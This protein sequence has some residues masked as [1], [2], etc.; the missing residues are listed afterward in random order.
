MPQ[1]R[2]YDLL[3]RYL[4][5]SQNRRS[6]AIGE[7]LL[8]DP[9]EFD[10]IEGQIGD[11]TGVSDAEL[12]RDPL[13][14][15]INESRQ[16]NQLSV[17]V[18]ADIDGS[19][20]ASAFYYDLLGQIDSNGGI[21]SSIRRVLDT[22]WFAWTP[23]FDPDRWMNYQRYVWLGEGEARVNGEY[24]TKDPNG[25]R[26]VLHLV[27]GQRQITRQ[28]VELSATAHPFSSG[29][30]AGQLREDCT[31]PTR[32]IYRWDGSAWNPVV[33]V[34]MAD[35][36]E[37]TDLPVGTYIY[38]ARAGY[39]HN[40]PLVHVYHSP[41]ARWISRMAV[42]SK[43]RPQSPVDGMIWEDP[44]DGR[45]RS[46]RRYSGTTFN[47]SAI[48]FAS[49]TT[50][51][52][53]GEG[54]DGDVVYC[55]L[56][57]ASV[58]DG[59]EKNNWWYHYDDLSDSDKSYLARRA[60]ATRPILQLWGCME[61]YAGSAR[62]ARHDRP[63]YKIY[64]Y[65]A[66]SGEIDEITADE[67]AD[68]GGCTV[69]EYK[70]GDGA[71]DAIL[72][73]PAS[74][75]DTGEFIFDLTLESMP[76][77]GL[78]GYRYFK[79][80][81]IG[82]MR[83]V[84]QEVYA[85]LMATE[86]EFPKALANNPDH[87]TLTEFSRSEILHSLIGNITA[88]GSTSIG[89]G[90][91][92]W[93]DM[94]MLEGGTLI[95]A[96]SSMLKPMAL[97]LDERLD[98]PAAIRAMSH[99]T[100]RFYRRFH[101]K[102]DELWGT[103]AY[104][105][106]DD[107]LKSGVTAAIM[108]DQVLTEILAGKTENGAF[109]LS[110]MGTYTDRVTGEVKPIAIPSSPPRVSATRPYVPMSFS[111]RGTTRLRG[112]DGKMIDSYGDDRDL[113]WLELE[114]R[115][116][117]EVPAPRKVETSTVSATIQTDPWI[118]DRYISNE[119]DIPEL[120]S[121][122]IIVP[123][124]TAVV[125]PSTATYFSRRHG[126]LVAY[127]GSAWG[128]P[129]VLE[130]GDRFFG[131]SNDLYYYNGFNLARQRVYDWNVAEGSTPYSA[132]E[133]RRIAQREF[134]RWAI[135]R[136]K[137]ATANTT[138]YDANDP[139]TWNF[140]SA[141]I[142]GH[143]RGIYRR[144]YG[145]DRPHSH[146]WEIYGF[147]VEPS[148]WRTTFVPTTTAA[149]GT[150]RYGSAHAMW[151]AIKS[152]GAGF[153]IVPKDWQIPST[154]IPVPVDTDGELLDPVAAG[155]VDSDATIESARSDR[156]K[157]GDFG[158]VEAE[159]W[160]S[161]EAA[162][163]MSLVGFLMK[164]C[165]FVESTWTDY[166][167]P[168]GVSGAA[169]HPRPI[170]VDATTLKRPRIGTIPVHAEVLDDG[171]TYQNPALVSWISESLI[172]TG[173]DPKTKF[174]DL[175]RNAKPSLGW[176]C[177]G[178]I[179]P[180]RTSIRT[181]TG[182]EIPQED[183]QVLV[184]ESRP[185]DLRFHSG[186][187]IV[188]D[189]G[190]AFRVYGY[191][192]ADPY[193]RTIK[194]AKP[195]V[196]GQVFL[197]DNFTATSG[198]TDFTVTS[199]R[200]K[201]SEVGQLSVLVDGYRID[202][203]YVTITEP[204][205]LTIGGGLTIRAGQTVSVILSS[206]QITQSTRQRQFTAGGKTFFYYPVS[207]GE[208]QEHQYGTAF[209]TNQD[210]VEFLA[211][212]GKWMASQG[213]IYGDDEDAAIAKNDWIAVA[214]RFAEWSI[215][216]AAGEIFIDVAGGTKLR[217]RVD[218]GHVMDVESASNGG[219]SVLDMGSFP[220]QPSE[221]IVSR[222]GGE[223]TIECATKEIYGLRIRINEIEHAVMISSTT[224]FN[225][226]IYQPVTGLRHLR[227]LV[228]TYRSRGWKGRMEAPGHL[229][230]R[231]R[232][233]PNFEK[234][235]SDIT[236]LYD[237]LNPV[238]DGVMLGQAWN[239]Y[240]WH[241]KAYMDD[242]G[243]SLPFA[244]QYHRGL[245]RNKGTGTAFK[246][247][248]KGTISGLDGTQLSENWAWK[249]AEYGS[250]GKR[251]RGRFRIYER[252]VRDKVQAFL[253]TD[254]ETPQ[255]SI[256]EVLPFDREEQSSSRWVIPPTTSAGVTNMSFV[257]DASG[258]PK[259]S[260]YFYRMSLVS[261]DSTKPTVQRFFHWD[262]AAGLHS[263][264][265]QSEIDIIS[266]VDPARYNQG[267][268]A[269]RAPGFEWGPE[270][271]GTVWWDTSKRVY[272]DYRATAGLRERSAGWGKIAHLAITAQVVN[273]TDVTFTTAAAHGYAAGMGVMLVAADG[274]RYEASIISIDDAD[275]FTASIRFGDDLEP[276]FLDTVDIPVFY[277]V[278]QYDVTVY[279]WVAS[280][281]PPVSYAVEGERVKDAAAPSYTEHNVDGTA[282][283]CFWVRWKRTAAT[284]KSMSIKRIEDDLRDPTAAGL[285]WFA[286]ISAT[287]M[288]ANMAGIQVDDETAVDV[289]VDAKTV[290]V[291]SEWA[292][293][294]DGHSIDRTPTEV[295]EKL[296]DSLLGVD[297][298]GG[299]VPSAMLIGEERYGSLRGQ[300]V[301]RDTA[302]ARAVF[303]GA[304][305]RALRHAKRSEDSGFYDTFLIAQHGTWWQ[306]AQYIDEDM[307]DVQVS[308]IATDIA[309][310]NTI[311]LMQE[312][313]LIR[314]IEAIQDPV[315]G[316]GNYTYGL[317]KY[318]D[319]AWVEFSSG[320]T[321]A[322]VLP[323]LWAR[324]DTR[325]LIRDVLA[326]IEPIEQSSV[327][328]AMISE[329]LHQND[330]C[331][332]CFKT[333][334]IDIVH[335]VEVAQPAYRPKDELGMI[336]DNVMETKP[337]HSKVRDTS[338]IVRPEVDEARTDVDDSWVIAETVRI[339]RLSTNGL[340]DMGWD[341]DGW[342]SVPWDLQPWEMS[343]QGLSEWRTLA[344][345]QAQASVREYTVDA[346]AVPG[347]ALRLL[348]YSGATETVVPAHELYNELDTQ[349]TVEFP[350]APP[351]GLTYVIQQ[352]WAIEHGPEPALPA[353][354]S[355]EYDWML[356]GERTFEH[357]AIR[358]EMRRLSDATV[359]GDYDTFGDPDGYDG[360]A[361]GE[362][363]RADATDLVS[364]KVTTYHSEA[365]AGWDA[366]PWDLGQW[367]SAPLYAESTGYAELRDQSDTVSGY[368]DICTAG[369]VLDLQTNDGGKSYL[370][371]VPSC[372]TIRALSTAVGDLVEGT[373][374]E[375]IG[376]NGAR[377][378]SRANVA[379]FADGDTRTFSVTSPFGI[380]GIKIGGTALTEGA[381]YQL[382][383]PTEVELID[384]SIAGLIE[385]QFSAPANVTASYSKYHL[386]SKDVIVTRRLQNRM[387]DSSL[388]PGSWTATGATIG[389]AL[390]PPAVYYARTSGPLSGI[391]GATIT[392]SSSGASGNIQQDLVLTPTDGCR[393]RALF[394]IKKV[395]SA[396]AYPAFMVTYKGATPADSL[397]VVDAVTGEIK[398]CS[399]SD[400]EAYDLGD[401]WL[402]A[403]V[404]EN[405]DSGN[406]GAEVRFYPAYNATGTG[407]SAPTATGSATVW[408]F[409]VADAALGRA[410]FYPSDGA[411]VDETSTA[412][413][414]Y[415]PTEMVIGIPEVDAEFTVFYPGY[416][417]VDRLRSS[418]LLEMRS[419]QFV[420]VDDVAELR[421]AYY[422]GSSFDQYLDQD[423]FLLLETDTSTIFERISGG[424]T[425]YG[426]AVARKYYSRRTREIWTTDG[427]PSWGTGT[428]A[429]PEFLYAFRGCAFGTHAYGRADGSLD[430]FPSAVSMDAYYGVPAA[431]HLLWVSARGARREDP[432]TGKIF[433]WT[434]RASATPLSQ[435]SDSKR[436]VL[437]IVGTDWRTAG[438]SFT[439]AAR[440]MGSADASL[441]NVW[442]AGASAFFVVTPTTF[443]STRVIAE[444][445]D[446]AGSGG[447]SISLTSTGQVRFIKDFSSSAA[448]WTTVQTM[449][450]GAKHYIDV[451]YTGASTADDPIIYIDGAL[452]T[453]TEDVAPSGTPSDDSSYDLTV[454]AK[455]DDSSPFDGMVHELILFGR[456]LTTAEAARMR[457]NLRDAWI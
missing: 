351:T 316:P 36:P 369:S 145:T 358:G 56:D 214:T 419:G 440:R 347:N 54:T 232:L 53:R 379:F 437:S 235:A 102:L 378:F 98:L 32:P 11:M 312:G 80:R 65:D 237:P 24:V 37:S 13:V 416:V 154:S 281:V 392:D 61:P 127:S 153:P 389:A 430:D 382:N 136:G 283:Y 276:I 125:G 385:V 174:G 99:E 8:Y 295:V 173:A 266:P 376:R 245:I 408:G 14:P 75:N 172:A 39:M 260:E 439:G 27:E 252:D 122:V 133:F 203:R 438:V 175:V 271:A 58:A 206:T 85:P 162:F 130:A 91:Y 435:A 79:D 309:D 384:G 7:D 279:Q 275:S 287:A 329:M 218:H 246:A 28:I 360:G 83:G 82:K 185:R 256:I 240:G 209:A 421:S 160:E 253:F 443:G 124:Y 310:R 20:E 159:F 139:F 305:N 217:F 407:T 119:E 434:N 344:T 411:D 166:Y 10:P 414:E 40:R 420:D 138:A 151:T 225:D 403:M 393:N 88:S 23:P 135:A 259:P 149:D 194:G 371:F 200:L 1:H 213:W 328:S 126:A 74:L 224:K 447:W 350:I 207:T 449:T 422:S 201:K 216:R 412:V 90:P 324:N 180:E 152:S 364:I 208:I 337:F 290:D 377:V 68:A 186:V 354:V 183:L 296:I 230:F 372:Y 3:P 67:V 352:A 220:I 29:T 417:P 17:A 116:Y 95:D 429:I 70:R 45:T 313:D 341:A 239:L 210:V 184:H 106:P 115:F 285:P 292:L 118:I 345:F 424:W 401:Y 59:W 398:H 204:S 454:G 234:Q 47:W 25:S 359:V 244:L 294:R 348:A 326:A 168:V 101:R 16:R 321:T 112:H 415:D 49:A 318:T 150:P 84:W 383:S 76:I 46:L 251:M 268:A 362:R 363:A 148:W 330:G 343:E 314:V 2:F 81:H 307:E 211:D 334:L 247:Y 355:A 140:S 114:N 257:V 457:G 21:T 373:D 100:G 176:R 331:S 282:L 171:S 48:T 169:L 63:R 55:S 273:D 327:V 87:D 390:D 110:D 381:D 103:G 267:T 338:T 353:A 445:R 397:M 431:D 161:P 320:A 446:P 409:S 52:A 304:L 272:S 227:L 356:P 258:A 291:H 293:I 62:A 441:D 144:I 451:V 238:D 15:E 164:P 288:A 92:R 299:A 64:A 137:D 179:N 374:F 188:K 405:N 89:S 31:D 134:E 300:T 198:Q 93:G 315:L 202:R 72:A 386:L 367:D 255:D 274:K 120:P 413:L 249:V 96:Q 222:I 109:W 236:R 71:D 308:V 442:A 280:A 322:E 269:N 107:T 26:T 284:G 167:L 380:S 131:T 387:A 146:P 18:V 9:E 375:R 35:V 448:Q 190:G 370:A 187:I 264:H 182:I 241:R 298:L 108:V 41:G 342:D 156:W 340:D 277:E 143:W 155:I 346:H 297:E 170:I 66:G 242:L 250:L 395:D 265:A 34:P 248:S 117:A 261:V 73:F 215:G 306:K 399:G 317:Y 113:V 323:A 262:P 243:A 233:L 226:L 111:F 163:I 400:A 191:D 455:T 104:S 128:D 197:R 132:N 278:S 189:A 5:T 263:P 229:I 121:D 196:A 223:M 450:S 43:D 12:A 426:S 212:H 78:A 311:T 33:F 319:G 452:A 254:A 123:D 336:L 228:K 423:G 30:T 361:P 339:D 388:D 270:R 193:F 402:F 302:A 77:D 177:G 50:M 325:Q 147:T 42:V 427:G 368:G 406:T 404:A 394:H 456:A 221:T 97:L 366:V 129:D 6:A 165:R 141:G 365:A 418:S 286:P 195:L 436:P 332:W 391:T 142:E 38:V 4:K 57:V 410:M 444:K 432:D 181:H 22:D 428:D 357:A 433:Q 425:T 333:S 178:F 69:L 303:L 231:D 289:S 205:T 219:Y 453:L 105:N 86:D 335:T 396:S 349:V 94:S 19:V 199:F 192:T 158:P 51:V 60:T 301:F 44:S 157:Y